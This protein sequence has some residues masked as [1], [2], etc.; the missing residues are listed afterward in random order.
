MGI[1]VGTVVLY[2]C[3]VTRALW[4]MC[5]KFGNWMSEEEQQVSMKA[6]E[7]NIQFPNCIGSGDGSLIPSDRRPDIVGN[8]Y[9]SRKGFFGV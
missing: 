7:E 2:C 1:G 3:H 4:E 5:R 6:I 9:L 8:N